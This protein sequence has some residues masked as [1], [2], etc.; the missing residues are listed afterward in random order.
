MLQRVH[1]D[2]RMADLIRLYPYFGLSSLERKKTV[3]TVNSS[4]SY[5][6][7]GNGVCGNARNKMSVAEMKFG[8]AIEPHGVQN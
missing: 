2:L 4:E 7:S 6:P 8:I 5:Q 3:D 1:S